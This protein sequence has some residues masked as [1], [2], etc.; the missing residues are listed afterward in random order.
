MAQYN[1]GAEPPTLDPS[2]ATDTTSNF[3][4]ENLFLGLTGFD[5][6]GNVEPELATDWTVSDDGLV[7]TFNM[8]DDVDLGE[9]HPQRRRG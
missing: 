4:I 7:Y 9:L 8:R 3:V 5:E 1:L 2:L 6:E